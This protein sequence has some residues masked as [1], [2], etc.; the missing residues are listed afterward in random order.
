MPNAMS[1][2]PADVKNTNPL[3]GRRTG[4]AG[5][6]IGEWLLEEQVGGGAFGEVW[7]ARHHVWADQLAA[8]KLPTDP[9][10][11]RALQREGIHA[12]KLE[13]P[14]IVRPLGFDP[15]A[16]QPYLVMEFVPGADLRRLLRQGPLQPKQ[17]T[18]VLRQVLMALE[19]AHAHGIVHRDI[20]PENIL[21]HE[22]GLSGSTGFDAEGTVKVTD[23]GLGKANNAAE[24][25][26]AGARSIVF[27][28][29]VGGGAGAEQFKQIAGSLEYMAPE[30]RGGGDVDGRADLYACGVVLY[31]MLVGD[32]PAGTDLPSDVNKHVPAWLDDAFRHSYARLERRFGSAA[33]FLEALRP[34]LTA[35]GHV[36]V[37]PSNVATQIG[38]GVA[39]APGS[40][41]SCHG[42][43]ENGDQ[44]CISCGHQL[45]GLVRR[46]GKCGAF[47]A[48]GDS[49]CIFCGNDLRPRMGHGS[50]T[51]AAAPR[52]DVPV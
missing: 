15:F 5:Q 21:L 45:V 11:V 52:A 49:Y 48:A 18:A 35:A 20:K 8:V 37:I 16:E 4:H 29:D 40:C 36:T 44:F 14:N 13:H 51:G 24:Q 2:T 47:P 23:F 43:V 30:Q 26:I 19:H 12:H 39:S 9:Q 28:A 42:R 34:A 31:E 3:A 17:A 1:N 32:R 27:S 50:A 46:C 7:R 6:R 38:L 41:P 22:R 10:Y 25:A 33:D